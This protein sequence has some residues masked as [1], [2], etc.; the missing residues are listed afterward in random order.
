VAI[1]AIGDVQGCF[2]ELQ[3]LLGLMEFHPANDQLWFAGD[4]VNRGPK[5]LDVLR[6][7]AG[8][9]DSARV[10]LGN[11]DLH[12][13]AA[14]AGVRERKSQDTFMSVLEA[15]DGHELIDW[16]A[17]QSM[18]VHEADPPFIMVHAG[19]PP[20]WDLADATRLAREVESVLRSEQRQDYLKHM[21]GNKPDRWREDLRGWKRLRFITNALTRM[22]YVDADGRLNLELEGPPGTQPQGWLPWFEAPGR[23]TIHEP[24]LFGH[25]ATLQLEGPVD[26]AHRVHHLDT[27]CVWGGRLTAIRLEDE[28]YFSVPS[29]QHDKRILPT[30]R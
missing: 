19:L 14:A 25:W 21:Y 17:S 11:H 27:G 23:R 3:D 26:S 7:V 20:Q 13:V 29:R 8:L 24:I 22:R 18:L 5:S 6:F 15:S 12:L 2:D 4:L 9:G 30:L 16:L 28:R 10:V 1:Y